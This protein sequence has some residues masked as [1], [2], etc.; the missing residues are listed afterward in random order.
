MEMVETAMEIDGDGSGHTSPS[1]KGAG[2][3]TS[4]PQN[5]SS[6]AAE[7]RNCSGKNADCF[8]VFLRKA[9]YRRRGGVR[10]PPVTSRV[11]IKF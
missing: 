7:M 1:W 9:F 8:R 5:L 6:M 4:I 10:G 3:Q 2:I 11:F